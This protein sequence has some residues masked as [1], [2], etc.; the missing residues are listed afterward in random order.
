MYDTPEEVAEAFLSS[1]T[2]TIEGV[3]AEDG[4]SPGLWADRVGN[5]RE[6]RRGRRTMHVGTENSLPVTQGN[7]KS[8]RLS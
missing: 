4:H 2:E 7:N 3:D 6:W 8:G 5:W 1:L